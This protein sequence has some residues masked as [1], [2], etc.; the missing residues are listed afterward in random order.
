MWEVRSLVWE[1]SVGAAVGIA[2]E[3]AIE[4]QEEIDVGN[5]CGDDEKPFVLP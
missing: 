4:M 5:E 3:E 2:E 1:F